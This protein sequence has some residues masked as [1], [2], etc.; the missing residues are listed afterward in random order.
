MSKFTPGKWEVSG[1]DDVWIG[2]DYCIHALTPE[3]ANL[4]AAAPDLLE[5]LLCI[6]EQ[7]DH[8]GQLSN[9][10]RVKAENALAKARGE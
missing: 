2:E 1:G 3:N 5:A 9:L 10:E 4:I 7:D 8:H 6:V